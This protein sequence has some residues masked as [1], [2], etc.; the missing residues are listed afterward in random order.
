MPSFQEA[1]AQAPMEAMACGTPVIAFP[2]SGTDSLINESN[3][4]VCHDFTVDSLVKNIQSA[5]EIPFDG[6]AIRRDVIERF[7]YEKIAAQYI[8]LYHQ[9][10]QGKH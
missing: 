9:I 7:S 1:F 2:C 3:G 5:K 8:D 4:I 6:M 10:Q